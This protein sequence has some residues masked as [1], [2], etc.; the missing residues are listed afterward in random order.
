[1]DAAPY[2]QQ[3][4]PYQD[5][6]FVETLVASGDDDIVDDT[7]LTPSTNKAT[8]KVPENDG[9][10]PKVNRDREPHSND[11]QWKQT[12]LEQQQNDMSDCCQRCY[13]QALRNLEVRLKTFQQQITNELQKTLAGSKSRKQ[14]PNQS[15]DGPISNNHYTNQIVQVQLNNHV[16]NYFKRNGSATDGNNQ[17]NTH[18]NRRDRT[19]RKRSPIGN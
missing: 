8:R 4:V 18:K 1:M 17:K 9:P 12:L 10:P 15:S 7:Y 13:I 5:D 16:T 19:G 2:A 14:R 11:G 6:D 3:E